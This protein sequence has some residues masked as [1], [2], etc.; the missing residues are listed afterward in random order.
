[1]IPLL[2]TVVTLVRIPYVPSSL[3]TRVPRYLPGKTSS[4]SKEAQRVGES[5]VGTRDSGLGDVEYFYF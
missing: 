4:T 5:G 2:F 1:M 3:G